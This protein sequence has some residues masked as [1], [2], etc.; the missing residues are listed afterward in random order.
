MVSAQLLH[1]ATFALKW[2]RQLK[3]SCTARP[4]MKMA[5]QPLMA[6]ASLT[7]QWATSHNETLT[8]DEEQKRLKDAQPKTVSVFVESAEPSST[9]H[10]TEEHPVS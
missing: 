3:R 2:S 9:V 10:R 4:S 6:R 8:L 1:P 5:Q 7:L